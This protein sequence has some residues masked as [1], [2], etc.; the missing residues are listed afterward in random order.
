MC[1]VVCFVDNLMLFNEKWSTSCKTLEFNTNIMKLYYLFTLNISLYECC[2]IKLEINQ[3]VSIL[4]SNN[5]M[6]DHLVF[7]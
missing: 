2:Y 7:V 6:K 3:F 4:N 1:H 5:S